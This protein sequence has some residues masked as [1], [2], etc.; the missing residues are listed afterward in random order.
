MFSSLEKSELLAAEV[1]KPATCFCKFKLSNSR[2][3]EKCLVLQDKVI[4]CQLRDDVESTV[5][6]A[7]VDRIGTSRKQAVN[8][9]RNRVCARTATQQIALLMCKENLSFYSRTP[10]LVY[11]K[12][13]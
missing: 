3:I 10:T 5:V 6:G 4:L 8:D 1:A 9:T 12:D 2:K 11:Y 7:V 13:S